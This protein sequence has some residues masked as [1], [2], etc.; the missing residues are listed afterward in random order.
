MARKQRI[1]DDLEA[2]KADGAVRSW[3]AYAPG[4]GWQ[5]WIVEVRGFGSQ[6]FTTQ[7]VE[8]YLIGH[9]AAMNVSTEGAK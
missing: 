1:A 5:R 2:A 6:T 9:Q 8:A 3:Y 7:Q 4:D